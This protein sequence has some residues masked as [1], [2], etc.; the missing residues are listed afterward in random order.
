MKISSPILILT[1]AF[2]LATI[3]A[4]DNNPP[5]ITIN[6]LRSDTPI[7]QVASSVTVIDSAQLAQKNKRT[8]L[9]VLRTVPGVTVAASGGVGQ[10][11]RVFLRGTNSNHVLVVM[12]GVVLN[13]PSDP[14]TA[15]DF[16]NLTTD[17]IERIEV[18][19]GPQSAL[20]GSQAF[21]GVINISSKKGSGAPKYTG[22]AEYG[23]YN[24][25][26]L[27]LGTNG[28]LGNTSYS[29]NAAKSHT[30]GVSSFGKKY[31]GKEKDGNNTYTFSGN[32]QSRLTDI[33]T[34]KLNGRY[35]R[36]DTDF[37]S[38]GSIGNFGARPDDDIHP[39]TD[40]RQINL[41][42]SGELSLLGGKW[43]QE[44]GLSTLN[45]NRQNISEYFDAFFAPQ[46]GRQYYDGRRDTVDWI[47]HLKLLPQH[48]T[49]I[50]AE[51]YTDYFK[52][53]NLA[54]QNAD[55]M[56]IFANDQYSFTPNLYVNYG[57]R[58][59]N[60]Q[61]F[62]KQFTYRVAPGYNIAST[63]TRVKA[64]YGTSYKAPSLAQLFDPTSGNT[65]LGP[66][67]SKGYDV[68]FEQTLWDDKITFG[69]TY[70]RNNITDLIGFGPS[71]LF[72][73]LNVGKA[74]TQ[75]VENNISIKPLDNW[76]MNLAH[77]YTLTENRNRDT[78]LLRRPKH[79]VNLGTTYQYSTVG[80]I[81]LNMRYASSRRDFYWSNSA[82]TT[83]NGF[84]VFDVSTNYKVNDN[85]TVYAR[86]ENL[87][88][89]RYEEVSGY[90]MPG[91]GLYV[92]V[93]AS[94]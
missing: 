46:F 92:G 49:T 69:S 15:F 2:P 33:F 67:K 78:E 27:E 39:N 40:N 4:D 7:N 85:A 37:D 16:S 91:V 88:D 66:E 44:L 61:S 12:D 1:A 13:D 38:V 86:V 24:S 6:A 11:A 90:G 25:S 19:R 41:R 9:D 89:K 72:L 84:T 94:Y 31:G 59:D 32:V 29:F 76:T 82:L 42:G 62:G 28:E 77:T 71:P 3:A 22:L 57:G 36:T 58:L 14:A 47:H 10:N 81:G 55:N 73:T 5:H 21:G 93:K 50:G 23:R 18:L 52:T 30:D 68:G 17:N 80:D 65:D 20:Y 75:G 43:V 35:N 48:N 56:A 45:F 34:A 8:A 74:R 64:S 87:L 51:F 26:K 70:F 53:V 79:Q 54:S 63:G 60:H 83:L